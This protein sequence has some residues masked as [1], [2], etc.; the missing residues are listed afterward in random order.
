MQDRTTFHPAVEAALEAPL[1]PPSIA[2]DV[3]SSI[4]EELEGFHM[5]EYVSDNSCG[6]TMCFAGWTV[7]KHGGATLG[8]NVRGFP[9]LF[10]GEDQLNEHSIHDIAKTLLGFTSEEAH[11]F[12]IDIM[13]AKGAS[14]D[15]KEMY[16]FLKS[17]VCAHFE[18]D[19]AII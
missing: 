7:F 4:A 6:T 16:E 15:P 2:V 11:Y 1:L 5:A 8:T 13:D 18:I 14:D 10:S 17:E 9:A 19:P 3:L 12:F